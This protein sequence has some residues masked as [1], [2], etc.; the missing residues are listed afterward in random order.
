MI[1]IIMVVVIIIGLMAF[2]FVTIVFKKEKPDEQQL[3]RSGGC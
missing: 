2:L 3:G 1:I